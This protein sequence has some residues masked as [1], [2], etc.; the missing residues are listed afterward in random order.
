MAEFTRVLKTTHQKFIKGVIDET[1]E[2]SI[3]LTMLKNRGKVTYKHSGTAYEW[4]LKKAQHTLAGYT[5]MEKVNFSRSDLYETA[6][7]AWRG[8]NMSDAIS[9]KEKLM[10]RGAEAII[11][12][13]ERLADEMRTDFAD[14]LNAQLWVDG[15]LSGN[16]KLLHGIASITGYT[17]CSTGVAYAAANDTYAGLSMA[18]TFGTAGATSFWSPAFVNEQA[19]GIGTWASQPLMIVRRLISAA[20]RTNNKE[21]RPDIVIT[22]LTRYNQ[23]KDKLQAEERFTAGTKEVLSAGF[24]GIEFDGVPV[25]WDYDF[26]LG[27]DRLTAGAACL[28]LKK[29][30][31]AIL[32]DQLIEG[33]VDYDIVQKAWLFTMDLFGNLIIRSPRHQ[34]FSAI[35]YF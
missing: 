19:T 9:K 18:A 21:S 4:K 35:Y 13:Y 34:A 31:L 12:C 23:F 17:T 28:N 16:E 29:M 10:N 1:I 32:G 25:V 30:D 26:T 11:N 22:G 7:L 15:N 27:G 6:S 14:Q 20:T 33:D 5:D 3:L 2:N 8:Y 24:E